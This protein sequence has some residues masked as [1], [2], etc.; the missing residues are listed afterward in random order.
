ML[1]CWRPHPMAP[2]PPM[3]RIGLAALLELLA[4]TTTPMTIVAV[5]SVLTSDPRKLLVWKFL[6][7]ATARG[8]D[9]TSFDTS[10]P[11]NHP[12]VPTTG[13]SAP[14]MM[15]ALPQ[16]DS[17]RN[18]PVFGT[19]VESPAVGG[20][21]EGAGVAVPFAAVATGAAG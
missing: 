9:S 1:M 18:A 7:S 12:T 19:R 5:P 4:D 8:D 14:R 17:Y 2:A 21:L 10:N 20:R 15:S 11:R 13:P 6:A 16:L 3:M